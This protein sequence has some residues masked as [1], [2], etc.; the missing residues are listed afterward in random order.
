MF[1][2]LFILVRI[3]DAGDSVI[4]IEARYHLSLP[5]PFAARCQKRKRHWLIH[6]TILAYFG[7]TNFIDAPAALHWRRLN[8]QAHR[9]VI[10]VYDRKNWSANF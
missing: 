3:A 7:L 10:V 8:F 2:P 6:F 9:A 1:V 4:P 5:Y